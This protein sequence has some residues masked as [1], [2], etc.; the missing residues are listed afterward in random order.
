M[1]CAK[2]S[3]NINFDQSLEKRWKMQTKNFIGIAISVLFL[4]S[5]GAKEAKESKQNIKTIMEFK[6]PVSAESVFSLMQDKKS[7]NPEFIT[8]LKYGDYHS[9]YLVKKDTPEEQ[10]RKIIKSETERLKMLIKHFDPK[11]PMEL[12]V[13]N[14]ISSALRTISKEGDVKIINL[15]V[16][17]DWSQ[18]F[19]LLPAVK[20]IKVVS[21]S[22]RYK[23]TEAINIRQQPITDWPDD[24]PYMPIAGTSTIWNT[25]TLQKFWFDTSALSH[26]NYSIEFGIEMDTVIK[27]DWVVDTPVKCFA[28]W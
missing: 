19:Y 1:Y 2:S 14:E 11:K 22:G 18:P 21:M 15:A 24:A 13:Y 25:G 10:L 12:P 5:C 6:K 4:V 23:E 9:R 26:Y 17:G 28:G 8:T 3:L 27:S 20:D 16:K 7:A